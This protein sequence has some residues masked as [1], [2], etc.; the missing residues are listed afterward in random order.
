MPAFKESGY[1]VY[2]NYKKPEVEKEANTIE[3]EYE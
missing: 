1:K 3:E 2:R